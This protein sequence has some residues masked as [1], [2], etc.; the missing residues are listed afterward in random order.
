MNAVTPKNIYIS[1]R[2]FIKRYVG[3]GV[4]LG[5]ALPCATQSLSKSE[6]DDGDLEGEITAQSLSL[7][8]N[9]YYEFSTNK[10]SISVLSQALTTTPWSVSVEGEVSNPLI[11]PLESISKFAIHKRIYRFRCVEGWSMVVPW[12]GILLSDLVELVQ[13]T[14][15]AK[16]IRFV[17]LYRP[18]E[19][20]AQ[21]RNVMSWPYEEGLR[22]DEAVHPLTMLATGIYDE[23]LAKQSGGPIRLIVPW[24]YGF[25]S[26]KAITK[27]I[28]QEDQPVSTWS[29]LSPREYGFYA[30]VNPDVAHPRWSQR[31]E[32]PLGSYKKIKTLPFNGYKAEVARL[33]KEMD[34]EIH[35]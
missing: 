6:A 11:L 3:K 35:Y 8:Y 21:R 4:L 33:Y 19:M 13:P 9:N 16:Y 32:L 22:L 12:S 28:F 34:L 15:K 14:V 23:P 26:I 29:Q 24:K 1:R 7:N 17:G 20:I 30:N 31:R 25:K 27:I 18:S 10:K 2:D 5:A